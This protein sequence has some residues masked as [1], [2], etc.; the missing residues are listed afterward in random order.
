MITSDKA[1]SNISANVRR[2]LNERNMSQADLSRVT[3]DQPMR[4]SYCIRGVQ[5]PSASFLARIAEALGV[6][7]DDLLA[8]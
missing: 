3:G 8:D 5:E 4:L 7:V 2:L 6:S 1:K